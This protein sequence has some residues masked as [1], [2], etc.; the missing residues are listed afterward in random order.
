MSVSTSVDPPASEDNISACST[1]ILPR[2][3]EIMQ[4][5]HV[6]KCPVW[7]TGSAK[8]AVTDAFSSSTNQEP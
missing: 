4:V 6:E 8:A 5:T 2:L 7:D 3:N 1:E